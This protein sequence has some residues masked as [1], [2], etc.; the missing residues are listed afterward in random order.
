[1]HPSTSQQGAPDW[2][3]ELSLN[4]HRFTALGCVWGGGGGGLGVTISL[5]GA[6]IFL[7]EQ[8]KLDDLSGTLRPCP[9]AL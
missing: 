6:T 4:M 9:L 7:A 2:S 1:M 3:Q 8:L 5:G